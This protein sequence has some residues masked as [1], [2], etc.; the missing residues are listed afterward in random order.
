[1]EWRDERGRRRSKRARLLTGL[2]NLMVLRGLVIGPSIKLL[3]GFMGVLLIFLCVEG[4]MSSLIYGR[5]EG[6]SLRG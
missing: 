4:A 1:M 2:N 5:Q 6:M 3:K